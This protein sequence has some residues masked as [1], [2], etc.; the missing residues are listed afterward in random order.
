VKDILY[1]VVLVYLQGYSRL[2]WTCV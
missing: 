2:Y 1:C